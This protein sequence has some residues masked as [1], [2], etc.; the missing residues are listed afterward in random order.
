[1]DLKVRHNSKVRLLLVLIYY[2]NRVFPGV[3][4][5]FSR[6]L[7]PSGYEAV[8][9]DQLPPGRLNHLFPQ[10]SNHYKII[11]MKSLKILIVV[12]VMMAAFSSCVVRAGAY[13]SHYVPGHYAPGYYHEHW[14]PGHW[15]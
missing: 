8:K 3:W 9:T 2:K 6:V 13:G 7:Q 11:H 5:L 1:M 12:F 4:S 10:P 14:V 15:S